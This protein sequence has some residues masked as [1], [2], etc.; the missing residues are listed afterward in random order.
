MKKLILSVGGFAL[1]GLSFGQQRLVLAESFSQASCGPCAAQNPALTTL[2]NANT[3]KIVAVKYQVSWPGYDPMYNQNPTEIDARTTY[4]GISGVPDRVQ[5]GTNL[6]VTQGTIDSRYAVPSPVNMTISHTISSDFATA[7]ITVT[8]DAPAIWNPSNTVLQLAMVEKDITFDS[9]PGSNGETAFHNVMRKMLP[10]ASGTPVVASNFTMAGG[11]QTFTF[12]NVAIPNYIYKL[13]QLSFVAWVQNNTTKE[14]HQAGVSL[15]VTLNNFGVVSALAIPTAFSC[16]ADL[17]GSTATLRND[18]GTVITTATVN[19]QIDNGTLQTAPFT[20]NIA[21]GGTAVFNIPTAAIP[22]SGSHTLTTYL[23]NINGSGSTTPIGTLT[24]QFA[25]ITA[26]GATGAFVQNFA[27]AAFPYTNYYVASSTGD[28]WIRST[29]NGGS[30]RFNNYSFSAGKIGETTLAPIDLASNTNKMMTFDV[31]YAQYQSEND[32]LEVLV[33]TDCGTTW[34]SVYNKAGATLAT[35]PAQTASFVPT[36]ANQWRNESVDL[37]SYGSAT[38][39]FV[40]FKATSAYGNNV[41]VDN[42]NMGGSLG[43]D[44]ANTIG[45]NVYPNPATNDLKVSFNATGSYTTAITD[46]Q[47]RTVASQTNNASGTENV[48][49]NVSSLAKGSYIVTISTEGKT[50]TKNVVVQ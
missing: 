48:I 16:V 42:I 11:T 33:S 24:K 8:I 26:N 38:K 45:L 47:G 37:A 36:L 3:S 46:L 22:T 50:Y 15:P 2:L 6:D 39:L 9:A 17:S 41:F 14:V 5:D 21:L 12:T 18:G 44:E 13:D 20:G 35:A 23:T 43:I 28:N 31:A 1:A 25:R 32:R 34:T 40:K 27:S 4:Y 7:N 49:F 19:Y 10:N 30:M 29:A